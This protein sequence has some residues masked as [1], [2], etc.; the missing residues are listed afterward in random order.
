VSALPNKQL[1]LTPKK[2]WVRCACHRAGGAAELRDV[3]KPRIAVSGSNTE[4][5]ENRSQR[6]L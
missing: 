3:R 2:W 1:L 4:I 5:E 6:E